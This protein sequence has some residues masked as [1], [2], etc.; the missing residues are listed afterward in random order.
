MKTNRKRPSTLLDVR[1]LLKESD[2]KTLN[3]PGPA[4]GFAEQLALDLNFEITPELVSE[5]KDY[6]C[7]DLDVNSVLSIQMYAIWLAAGLED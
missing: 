5:I 3:M 2:I 6:G 4:D 1:D 7:D